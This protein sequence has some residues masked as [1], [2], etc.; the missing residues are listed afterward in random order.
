M[1]IEIPC[2]P[3]GGG[4]GEKDANGLR[5]VQGL[6]ANDTL[7]RNV[8]SKMEHKGVGNNFS[9]IMSTLSLLCC[10]FCVLTV[11]FPSTHKALRRHL[12][13]HGAL[14]PFS[15][16]KAN[17]GENERDVVAHGGEGISQPKLP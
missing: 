17:E 3:S 8:S 10:V 9:L 1:N 12:F 11:S 7:G 14:L 2:H 16:P 13:S 5:D 15:P 6:V 4:D